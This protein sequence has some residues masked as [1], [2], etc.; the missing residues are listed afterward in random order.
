MFARFMIGFI[1]LLSAAYPA[2]YMIKQWKQN[3][4]AA[5]CSGLFCIATLVMGTAGLLLY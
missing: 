4:K 5:V 1:A 2:A 3:K